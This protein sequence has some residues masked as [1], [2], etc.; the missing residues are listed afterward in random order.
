MGYILMQPS[1]DEASTKA[2]EILQARGACL[3]DA[4]KSGARLQPV[5]LGSCCCPGLKNT[6]YLQVRVHAVDGMSIRIGDFYGDFTFIG[7][8]IAKL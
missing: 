6:T 1:T 7:Y 5:D 8:A 2:D 3:F 4:S